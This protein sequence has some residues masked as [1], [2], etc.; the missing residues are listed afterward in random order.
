MAPLPIIWDF[1]GTILPLDPYD[2]EQTLML[3]HLNGS[4][5]RNRLFKPWFTRVVVHADMKEWFGFSFRIFKKCYI[6]AL[7]GSHAAIL[8]RVASQL[9]AKI[10][11]ADRRTYRGLAERGHPMAVVSCGTADLGERTLKIAGVADCF[12]AVAGNRFQMRNGRISG[13][14]LTVLTPGDKISA[15]RALGYLPERCVAVGDGYSDL[16]LLDRAL[17]PVLMDRTGAKQIK[18]AGKGYNFISS[19]PDI[20]QL[21]VPAGKQ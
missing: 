11:E 8:D 3:N 4:G 18:Y 5:G 19:V 9:A 2:S 7:K 6:Y 13:M 1:D 17:V 12:T 16:P 10:P 14:D 20:R 21:A 15:A